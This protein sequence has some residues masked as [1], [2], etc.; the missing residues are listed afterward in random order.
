LVGGAVVGAVEHLRIVNEAVL[1][2]QLLV[3]GFRRGFALLFA[4]A[5]VKLDNRYI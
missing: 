4:W 1:S 5:A 2:S 3:F